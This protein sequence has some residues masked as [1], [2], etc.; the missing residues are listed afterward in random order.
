MFTFAKKLKALRSEKNISQK[1]LAQY[2]QISPQAVSKWERK[3]GWFYCRRKYCFLY[4]LVG[5][6]A[7]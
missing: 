5:K 3:D 4:G 7:D 6:P 2:L 1:A